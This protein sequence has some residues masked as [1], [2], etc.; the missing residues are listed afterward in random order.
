ME[1]VQLSFDHPTCTMPHSCPHKHITFNNDNSQLTKKKKCVCVCGCAMQT[2]TDMWRPEIHVEYLLQSPHFLRQSL[3]EPG[4]HQLACMARASELFGS[5]GLCP[6]PPPVL[7]LQIYNTTSGCVC[8]CHDP[9]SG[10]QVCMA[11]TLLI[12]PS[13]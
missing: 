3:T 8:E 1:A 10:P 5:V 2:C 11:S 6:A 7:E 13:P 9:N 4:A 12:E